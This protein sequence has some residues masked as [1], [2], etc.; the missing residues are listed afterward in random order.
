MKKQHGR[1]VMSGFLVTGGAGFIGS[2]LCEKL[3]QAGHRVRVFDNLSTGRSENLSGLMDSIEFVEG[4]VR[5]KDSVEKA[6]KGVEYVI[7]LAAL[8]SV[9]GSVKDPETTHEVNATGTLRVLTAS[10]NAGVK[11]VVYASSCSVYGDPEVFPVN[12]EMPVMP[13]SPYAVSKLSGE[14]Y[15]RTF[16]RVY[17]LETVSLRYFNVYG[18]RQD[19]SSQYAAVLPKFITAF[20]KDDV[21]VIYGDGEQTRDFIHVD[22]CNQANMK[23]C[24]AENLAGMFFNVGSGKSVTINELFLKIGNLMGKETPPVHAE[25]RS[26]DI[27][28]SLADISKIKRLVS[29]NPAVTLDKGIEKTVEWYVDSYAREKA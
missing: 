5:D 21:P 13:Q 10:K 11:R 22:D 12:E 20:L 9:P 3:V 25:A 27:R 18:K 28:D 8:G 15:C 19:P 16:Y 6:V 17:G 2:N 24:S 14:F 1:K 7:H 23:A 29:Y 4:D 26:G